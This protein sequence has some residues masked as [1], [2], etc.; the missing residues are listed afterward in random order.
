MWNLHR[1]ALR[2]QIKRR[3]EKCSQTPR[4]MVKCTYSETR[5]PV[6]FAFEPVLQAPVS[7]FLTMVTPPRPSAVRDTPPNLALYIRAVVPHAGRICGLSFVRPI[8]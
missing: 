6:V 7:L 3:V 2:L 8:V 5:L 1:E 4:F